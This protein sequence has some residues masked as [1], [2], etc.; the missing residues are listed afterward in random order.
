[1]RDS[2]LTSYSLNQLSAAAEVLWWR[3]M[4]VADDYGRFNADPLIVLA[5]CFPLRARTTDPDVVVGWLDELEEVGGIQRYEVDGHPYGVYVNW[6]KYQRPARYKA[7]WPPPAAGSGGQQT[8]PRT[9]E[10]ADSGFQRLGEVSKSKENEKEYYDGR[11]QPPIAA[12][13]SQSKAFIL[14]PDQKASQAKASPRAFREIVADMQAQAESAGPR[15][16]LSE[17]Y[18]EELERQQA[19]K[20]EEG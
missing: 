4:V 3:L 19:E 9:G 12:D 14:T 2:A 15:R 8:I 13:S 18:S 11:Y 5:S 16:S 20:A 6:T 10:S 7:K 17:M 1:M